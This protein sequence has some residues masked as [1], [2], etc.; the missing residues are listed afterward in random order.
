M[1]WDS[2]LFIQFDSNRGGRLLALNVL[3]GE[4]LWDVKRNAAIS[5]AS[6][7]LVEHGGKLQL[8][9]SADPIVA[10]YDIKTG[11]ELWSNSCMM[12]EVGPSP[13]YW[14]GKIYA[15]NEY[16]QLV[17]I[18]LDNPSETIWEDDEYLPEVASPVAAEGI[19]VIA[20]SYGV[21]A[22]YDAETGDKLWEQEYGYGFYSS[23]VIADGKI[24]AIDMGG[25]MHVFKLSKEYSLVGESSLG[26]KAYA[27]PAFTEG[28]IYLRGEKH[29]FCIGE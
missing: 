20:T 29:L 5:W 16:A 8:V 13:G 15:A 28:R 10:G 3:N 22:C 7:I 21:L 27:T 4:T 17:A 1:V 9:L 11:E 23:P 14:N 12:G 24:Y 18:D 2:K 19:L 26:E 25:T 6:P